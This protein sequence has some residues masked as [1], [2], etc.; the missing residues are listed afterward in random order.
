MESAIFI[1]EKIN[2]IVREIEFNGVEDLIRDT[3]M[4]EIYC[5]ISNYSEEVEHFERKYSKGFYAFN[6][7]YEAGEE[8][9]SKYDDLMAWKFA[10]EG[11]EY[12]GKKLEEMKNVL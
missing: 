10:E 9:F 12:W 7:E 6:K 8:D 5:R 2:N 3:V 1:N 11:K 4:T